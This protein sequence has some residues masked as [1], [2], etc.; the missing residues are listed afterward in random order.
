LE[1]IKNTF[2]YEAA[3][4][5]DEAVAA[6]HAWLRL[7]TPEEGDIF[8]RIRVVVSN[9]PWEHRKGEDG[10]YIDVAA[11]NAKELAR[12]LARDIDLVSPYVETLLSG[13]QKQAYAFG[14]QLVLELDDI[15]TLLDITL[16]KI[17]K[18]DNLNLN[19][20]FAVGMYSG[21]YD[22]SHGYWEECLEKIVGNTQ[23]VQHYPHFVRTGIIQEKHLY[24]LLGLIAK[25]EVPLSA[26][27]SLS[28]GSVTDNLNPDEIARFCLSLSDLGGEASWLSLDIIYMYCHGNSPV[29]DV[30][31][32]E[33]KL[34]VT[35]VPL[36]K[37]SNSGVRDA[38]VWRDTAEKILQVRDEEFVVAIV[39]QLLF[40]SVKGFEHGAIWSYIKP[41][42]MDVMRGYADIVWP[43]F[44]KAI[45]ESE[46]MEQ[47][48]LMQLLD[49]E[50]S[51][52]NRMPSVFSV[53]PV[54]AVIEWCNENQDIGPQFVA[55]CVNI[56]EEIDD[57]LAPSGLF[58]ALLENFGH[59]ERVTS[60]LTSNMGTRGW[61]GS[62][63]PYLENDKAA[64]SVLLEHPSVNV[65]R[66]VRDHIAYIDK[67]IEYESTRDDERGLGIY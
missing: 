11:E 7:L 51:F 4:L 13:E 49:R 41:L 19:L 14:R 46:G 6:L 24:V 45:S 44:A 50:N 30:I 15:A 58:V 52:S 29:I 22:K 34:L 61:S 57:K 3:S 9:P 65:K 32:D 26:V 17:A 60:G 47:Y 27:H 1:S 33:I 42:L 10:H 8:E 35:R 28:Y 55:S 37:E 31:R 54:E 18:V 63:V 62:L 39:E 66:W 25:G 67:Q 56:L 36:D 40:A 43:M 64:L 59:D 23:L 38:H 21:I 5:N 2:E 16:D 53:L 20:N 12:E 48:W